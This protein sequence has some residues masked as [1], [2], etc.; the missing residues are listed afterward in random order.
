MPTDY[1]RTDNHL[2]LVMV[3]VALYCT[4]Q[5]RALNIDRCAPEIWPWLR[6]L[7]LTLRQCNSDVKTWFLALDLDN[8]PTTLTYNPNLAKAKFDLHTKNQG[9]RTNG[10]AVRVDA[11]G[12][13]L[14][15]TLSRSCT[16]RSIIRFFLCKPHSGVLWKTHSGFGVGTM[17]SKTWMGTTRARC[18]G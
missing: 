7:T 6:P 18:L 13:T 8:W 15:S 16:S 2:G 11:D 1:R 3:V 12:Q 4:R 10:S 17:P 9:H 5:S 14:P